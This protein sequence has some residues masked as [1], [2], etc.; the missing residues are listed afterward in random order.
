M[1]RPENPR[2]EPKQARSRQ[3]VDA[4]LE[5]AARVFEAHGYDA[6]NTNRVAEVA[7]VSVGS[8]YQYF[9]NKDALVTA[10][11][12]RHVGE[13]LALVEGVAAEAPSRSLRASAE[14]L[15]DGALAIHTTRPRLTRLLHGEL[16]MLE[17]T[18]DASAASRATFAATDRLLHAHQA[19]V[20]R[21]DT[22]LTSYAVIRLFEAL[23]HAAV[24]DPP[25]SVAPAALRNTIVDAVVG[26][27]IVPAP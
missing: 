26:Y 9:P 23:V 2:K 8:M 16:P 15:V 11:H 14:L 12:E 25:P 10:L 22:A 4:I 5:A 6:T 19:E 1:Q 24:L 18:H 20:R 17:R 21:S 27:L 3:L 7:G 13:V